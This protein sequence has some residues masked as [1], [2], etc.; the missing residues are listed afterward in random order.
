MDQHQFELLWNLEIAKA[1]QIV[2]EWMAEGSEDL[3][4]EKILEQ[5]ELEREQ[6]QESVRLATQTAVESLAKLQVLR[7]Q[8][9]Q[10]Q[11]SQQQQLPT[12]PQQQ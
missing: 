12:D 2:E 3:L 4:I 6:V 11:P 10:S 1:R 9:L 8:L 7:A 5:E